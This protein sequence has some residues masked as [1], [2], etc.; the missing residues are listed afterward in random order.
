MSDPT[1]QSR[2][3]RFAAELSA[4]QQQK[5][6]SQIANVDFEQL[7]RLC[8]VE[9]SKVDWS[10]IAERAEPPPAVR[11]G[12]TPAFGDAITARKR[13][14]KLLR[15][16][17]VAAILV[18]G[19]QGT[20]LG[21]DKPKGLFPIGPVSGRSLFQIHC[22]RLLAMM[23]RY[24]VS[25]PLFVMTSPATDQETR[26]Y[27][28]KNN[29]FGLEPE[30]LQVFCQGTM[31]AVDDSTGEVLL[32]EKHQ[33]A[34]SPDGHGGVLAA[35]DN[36][37]C[38]QSAKETGI[39]YFF[40]AQVDNPL[41]QLCDPSLLGY[42]ALAESQLTTQVVEKRF[43]TEKVGNVVLV[44]DKVQIIEYSDLPDAAAEKTNEDGSLKFWAGNIAVHIFNRDFLQS[45][46]SDAEGLPFHQAHKKV[47]FVDDSGELIEPATPNAIKFERFVFD[48]LPMAEKAIVVEGDAS[49]VFAPVKNAEDAAVDTASHSRAAQVALHRTWLTE[50][51]AIVP[52]DIQ[53]EIHPRWALSSEDIGERVQ[54][55]KFEAD[56]YLQ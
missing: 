24:D 19:G 39:E 35:L 46:A 12:R 33:I 10:S 40:Y 38:L 15:D 2:L 20:R 41:V 43:A 44:D 11:L 29:N 55:V 9:E 49:E 45:V 6:D 37:G 53:V 27:F 47:P 14:E 17:K 32:S 31:P 52:D 54:G 36:T 50:A 1:P 51:G 48:L 5:L 18:A 7:A 16:G 8:S 22:D 23:Q 25:I 34:L 4:E 3:R 28:A 13:G 56:T 42:H 26:E 30:Q 21:F